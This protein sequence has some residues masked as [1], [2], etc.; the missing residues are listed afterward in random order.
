MSFENLKRN[1]KKEKETPA[2]GELVN[3]FIKSA[4][5]LRKASPRQLES[6][7]IYMDLLQAGLEEIPLDKEFKPAT[8]K[9]YEQKILFDF[10]PDSKQPETEPTRK[11]LE[12]LKI[13]CK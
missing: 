7:E 8:C 5:Q 10:H 11:T 12:V 3:K 13:L 9:A 2:R 4:E 1:L 6:D